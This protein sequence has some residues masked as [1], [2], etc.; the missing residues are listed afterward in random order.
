MPHA[1]AREA[2]RPVKLPG[3]LHTEIFLISLMQ[4]CA[5]LINSATIGANRSE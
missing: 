5:S 1:K 3:P 4:T 2:R